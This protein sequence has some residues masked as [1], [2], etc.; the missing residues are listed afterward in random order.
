MTKLGYMR[1][2][3]NEDKQ[4]FLRQEQ[5]LKDAGCEIIF[6]DVDSGTKINRKGLEE[7]LNVAK[8]GDC[9]VTVEFSR[10]SRSVKQLI[11]IAETLRDNG[12]DYVSLMENVDTRTPYG[13]CFYQIMASLNALE[14][15]ILRERTKQGLEAAAAKGRKGGRPRNK[16]IVSAIA[17]YKAD[18]MSVSE[19]SKATGVSRSTLYRA[20]EEQGVPRRGAFPNIAK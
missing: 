3:T 4:S 2:S 6:K 12:I 18:E 17:L 9:V 14:V 19:I 11:E 10:I 20:L 15:N 16:N 5:Q 7:L 13:M 1:I 8:S